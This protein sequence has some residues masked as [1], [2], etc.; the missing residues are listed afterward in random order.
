MMHVPP[1]QNDLVVDGRS[2]QVDDYIKNFFL[3]DNQLGDKLL[4]I[5]WY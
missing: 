4:E 1:I 2:Y 5:R 3:T